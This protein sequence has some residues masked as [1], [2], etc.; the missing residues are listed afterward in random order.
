VID[1]ASCR[2][3]WRTACVGK[4]DGFLSYDVINAVVDLCC[5]EAV[6][7][8][9]FGVVRADALSVLVTVVSYGFGACYL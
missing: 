2:I 1:F 8:S 7:E 5:N 3:L 4:A 9:R 6:T